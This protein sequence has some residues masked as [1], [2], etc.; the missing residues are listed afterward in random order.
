MTI[1]D[2]NNR[3]HELMFT[4]G[5]NQRYHQRLKLYWA[6]LDRTIRI[7]VGVLAVLGLVFAIPGM[8]NG[9]GLRVAI[10]SLVVAIALNIVPVSD[11][12]KAH[13]EL[14]RAWSELRKDAESESVKACSLDGTSVPSYVADRL[15][16]MT[17][18]EHSLDADEPAPWKWLLARCQGDEVEARW[19]KG[20]R[21]FADAEKERER[22]QSKPPTSSVAGSV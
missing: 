1:Q 19:G 3:L 11:W 9:W 20:I 7:A 16:E 21:T 12:E 4:C 22:R 14:F 2:Y 10:L 15:C 5:M 17:G 8:D 18:K 6:I 13:A